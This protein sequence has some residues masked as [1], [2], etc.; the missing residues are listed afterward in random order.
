ML[1][2]YSRLHRVLSSAKYDNT[3]SGNF[4]MALAQVLQDFSLLKLS[5]RASLLVAVYKLVT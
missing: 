4:A 2:E 5:A 1:P 3:A